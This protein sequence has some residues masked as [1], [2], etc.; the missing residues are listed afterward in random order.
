MY[1]QKKMKSW[2]FKRFCM[3]SYFKL[4]V[5]LFLLISTLTLIHCDDPPPLS[6]LEKLPPKTQE[7]KGR[8]G[9]LVNG[10]A[11]VVNDSYHNGASY[12]RD[13]FQTGADLTDS[14]RDQTIKIV[15]RNSVLEENKTYAL[16]VEENNYSEFLTSAPYR[17]L[18]FAE[19]T[20]NGELILTKVDINN[21]IVSGE[22]EFTTVNDECDTVKITD[23]R[24]DLQLFL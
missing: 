17:C 4:F 5:A 11:W 6:E 18:Y 9:C 12:Q 2:I 21:R 10:K 16:A 24:F 1:L 15:I 22:F 3:M 7:G 8:F 20:L 19:H 13:V 23:G 14:N